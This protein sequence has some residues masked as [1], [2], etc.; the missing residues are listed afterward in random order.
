MSFNLSYSY[1]KANSDIKMAVL[2]NKLEHY[3]P[4]KSVYI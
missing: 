4:S 3:R 1:S 2:M